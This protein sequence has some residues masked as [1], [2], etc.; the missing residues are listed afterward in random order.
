[1]KIS[2]RQLTGFGLLALTQGALAQDDSGPSPF[3]I[4]S[5][6]AARAEYRASLDDAMLR[7]G[8][9]TYWAAEIE[10]RIESSL[11]AVSDLDILTWEFGCATT[12]CRVVLD[13]R[14]LSGQ[15]EAME[16]LAGMPGFSF[17]GRA[18]L[19]WRDDGSATTYIYLHRPQPE[20]SDV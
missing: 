16:A 1:M 17:P 19:E 13:H 4:E 5:E 20:D 9:D 12:L 2:I 3:E 6:R 8:R 18:D 15:Q 11:H 14:T 7:E 10:H